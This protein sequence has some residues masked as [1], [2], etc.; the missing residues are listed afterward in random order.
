MKTITVAIPTFNEEKNVREA[1]RRVQAVMQEMSG[2]D[3]EI[4]FFDNDSTDGT[5]QIIRDICAEDAHVKAIFNSRNFGVERSSFNALAAANGDAYICIMADLETPP[6]KIPEFVKHWEEGYP[7][8]F[9]QKVRS[10]KGRIDDLKRRFYYFA[11]NKLS[12]YQLYRHVT[13]FGLFDRK[14]IDAIVQLKDPEGASRYVIPEL[15]F[16]A[17][18]VPYEQGVRKHGK[19]SYSMYKSISFGIESICRNSQKP[20]HI[21]T[22]AG[23]GIAVL[24]LLI[25][26]VYLIL[27]LLLWDSFSAGF[28]PLLIGVF[29]LGAIQ[30]FC[31]GLIGEYVSIISERQRSGQKAPVIEDERINF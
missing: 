1:H 30:I 28:A 29:F 4:I 17:M 19:S 25:G 24:S 13:G 7:V 3:Y 31:I 16:R 5:R 26:L 27:K 21:M 6:E 12:D 8:V 23:F 15:G 11:V 20:L 9:G 22:V 18:L 14:V 10:D 2:Y